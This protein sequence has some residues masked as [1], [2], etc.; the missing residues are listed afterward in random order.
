M[1]KR[2]PNSKKGYTYIQADKMTRANTRYNA[3]VAHS[4]NYIQTQIDLDIRKPED[5]IDH[6]VQFSRIAG[7]HQIPDQ[8]NKA[9]LLSNHA[10]NRVVKIAEKLFEQNQD[11]ITAD[12]VRPLMRIAPKIKD[13]VQEITG[14]SVDALFPE[15]V[16]TVKPELA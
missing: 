2:K 6:L 10:Q 14:K 1:A 3:Y 15:L 7:V 5:S 13:S 8:D 16:S 11:T 12:T 4:L 9:V